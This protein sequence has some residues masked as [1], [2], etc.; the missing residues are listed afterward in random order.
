[1]ASN[2]FINECKNPAFKN[3]LGNILVD[4]FDNSISES[5]YLMVLIERNRYSA[6]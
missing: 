1:M 2:N 5:N 6:T 3:R 4:G